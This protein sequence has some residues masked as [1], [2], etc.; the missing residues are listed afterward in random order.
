MCMHTGHMQA[1]VSIFLCCVGHTSNGWW[2]HDDEGHGSLARHNFHPASTCKHTPVTLRPPT[3]L[4]P[5]HLVV[6]VVCAVAARY[7][8]AAIAA[9]CRCSAWADARRLD[10]GERHHGAWQGAR[11]QG[12]GQR[13]SGSTPK[14]VDTVLFRS[15]IFSS[16]AT[17][18][19]DW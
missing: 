12:T 3:P 1:C 19:C 10:G 16:K 8:E 14:D 6:R 13:R 4:R 9:T 17:F 2:A 7:I 18:Q 15:C 5:H 11:R